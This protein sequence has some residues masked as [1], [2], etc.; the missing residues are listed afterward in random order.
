[1]TQFVLMRF[2]ESSPWR[3]DK[4]V[5]LI[6][7]GSITKIY[8]YVASFLEG[9][10]RVLDLCCGTGEIILRA[11]RKGAYVKGIDINPSMLSVAREKISKLGKLDNVILEEKGVAELDSEKAD[12]YDAVTAVLCFSELNQNE[13]DYA[14]KEILRVLKPGGL[15][16]LADEVEPENFILRLI[17]NTI[18][19]LFKWLTF[20][21]T[22]KIT[23][24][25]KNPIASLR[26]VGF[27][28]RK[29]KYWRCRNFLVIVA[30]KPG[31]ARDGGY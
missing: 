26:N 10:S 22:G 27:Q 13:R 16:I 4:G 29:T 24:A 15:F 23:Q 9:K 11:I 18:R 14:F 28:I 31:A 2:L 3:Y 21:L 17:Y 20:T 19:I 25:I 7:M 30:E 1:M 5:R 6:T 12:S 8:D